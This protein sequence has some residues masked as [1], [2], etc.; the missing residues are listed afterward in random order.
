MNTVNTKYTGSLKKKGSHILIAGSIDQNKKKSLIS[1]GPKTDIF[2]D[3][4]YFI[5]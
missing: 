5:I 3:T 2:K 1:M 4:S